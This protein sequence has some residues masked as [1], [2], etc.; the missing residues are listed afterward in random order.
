MDPD[1]HS[2]CDGGRNGQIPKKNRC[3]EKLQRLIISLIRSQ[4][5]QDPQEFPCGCIPVIMN[6][7]PSW[8]SMVVFMSIPCARVSRKTFNPF[9]SI[10]VSPDWGLSAMSIASEGLQPPGTIK[11]RTPAFPPP[12]CFEM[13]SLNFVIALSVKPT[14]HA[15]RL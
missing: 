14:M 2:Q 3:S 9:F 13:N 8:K 5:L 10:V 4:Q 7:R 15:S 1:G 11:M 12:F 6:P